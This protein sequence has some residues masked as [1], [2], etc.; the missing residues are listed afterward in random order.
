MHRPQLTIGMP[1]YNGARYIREALDS[2]LGQT[3]RDF[4]IFISDNASTDA[5]P[6]IC[7]EY[8]RRDARIRVVRQSENRGLLSNF[9]AVLEGA[10]GDMFTWAAADDVWDP[11]W[12]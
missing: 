5:T 4:E 7:E 10:R 8:R 2:L 12:L 3:F 6:E 11:R 9:R 1:V